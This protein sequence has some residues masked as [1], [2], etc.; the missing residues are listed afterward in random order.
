MPNPIK[1]SD[2]YQDDGAIERAIEQLS[3][4]GKQIEEV[5]KTGQ[6]LSAQLKKQNVA[7]DS[8]RQQ[9]LQSAKAADRLAKEQEKLRQAYS[10]QEKEILRLREERKKANRQ[11]RL[12]IKAANAAKG[13]YEQLSAQYSINKQRLN[14]MTQAQRDAAE[15]SEGLVTR[16]KEIYEEMKTLQEETG[17]TSLSD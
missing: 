17:K 15:A 7:Q 13:S 12:E 2:I 3:R 10:D 16:T 14:A 11:T 9:I 5:Q 8:G 6:G 1:S 4:L